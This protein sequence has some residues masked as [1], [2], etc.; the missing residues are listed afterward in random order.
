MRKVISH[1]L[2]IAG[3]AANNQEVYTLLT[4]SLSPVETERLQ[5]VILY[6]EQRKVANGRMNLLFVML[7]ITRYNYIDSVTVMVLFLFV[8]ESRQI[9]LAGGYQFAVTNVPNAFLFSSLH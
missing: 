4:G 6:A 9:E 7:F 5:K 8:T 2:P 1:L 3:L